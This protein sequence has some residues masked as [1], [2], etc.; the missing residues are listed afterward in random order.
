[1]TGV[2]RHE[3]GNQAQ[4]ALTAPLLASAIAGVDWAYAVVL[5]LAAASAVYYAARLR[6]IRAYRVQ[7]RLGFLVVAGLAAVPGLRGVLWVP[8]LGTTAQVLVG[9]CPMARL[10][11]LM[12]WNRAV[13]LTWTMIASVVTRRPSGEGLLSAALR[14]AGQAPAERF[15]G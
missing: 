1:M 5:G 9:Y 10:L 6:S 11:D 13:P 3:W 12:P 15:L 14:P 2:P 7:V 4:W 8:L